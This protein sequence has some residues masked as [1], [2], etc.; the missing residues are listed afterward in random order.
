M[1]KA[2]MW[3]YVKQLLYFLAI[4]I[5]GE[6]LMKIHFHFSIRNSEDER[7]EASSAFAVTDNIRIETSSPVIGSAQ[8]D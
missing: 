8:F 5:V 7:T 1:K 6:I 2:V 3:T 4:M